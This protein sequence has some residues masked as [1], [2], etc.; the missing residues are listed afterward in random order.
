[1]LFNSYAFIFLF[2]PGTIL[3]Y[4]A[5][6]RL[7]WKAGARLF[8]LLASFLFYAWWNPRY[9]LL[10]LASIGF[11]FCLGRRLS[12]L[13][14][15]AHRGWLVLGLAVNLGSIGYCKYADFFISN[16]NRLGADF[17]LPH[18]LLPLAISFFTFQQIAYLVD[19]YRGEAPPYTLLDYALFVSFFPQLIAGPIVCHDDMI[20]QFRTLQSGII[21][22]NMAAGLYQFILGL[23][24]KVLLADTFAL[25]ANYGF[26]TA[27]E[28][29]LGSAWITSLA[30]T[31]QLYFDFSGYSDMAL[32]AARM[33]NW[34]LPV[35]FRSPYQAS[36]LQD[37]WRRWHITLSQFL[38]NY[39]YI[40]LGGSR[41]SEGR[42]IVNLLITFLLGGLWHGA[43]WNFVFWGF[44][45]GAALSLRLLW[46]RF[47]F[48]LPRLVS[49]F[50]TFQF[51]NVAWVFFRAAS[52]TDALKVLRGMAGLSGRGW[53]EGSWDFSALSAL[54][55]GDAGFFPGGSALVISFGLAVVFLLPDSNTLAERL[56]PG[57]P[58]AL[59]AAVLAAGAIACLLQVSPFLYFN[60]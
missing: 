39:L 36:S 17:P 60:F 28:L 31:L 53:P 43:G 29:N 2:L 15:R 16:L 4:Y 49:W 52:G 19:A 20:R 51:V 26:D 45:H 8:L 55:A 21:P 37:F 41:R 24:K 33:F 50:L 42:T 47:F 40:P 7:K 12:A 34:R 30:Y 56:R 46:R 38:Q 25:W 13:A 3:G 10:L 48:P 18:I 35:N 22:Q 58:S 59:L 57:L 6:L 5:C 27:P 44:L 11:N 1:V 14:P 54:V 32:G 9:L 23:S